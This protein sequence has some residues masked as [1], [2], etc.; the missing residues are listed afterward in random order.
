M[1]WTGKRG[2]SIA[3]DTFKYRSDTHGNERKQVA[4]RKNCKKQGRRQRDRGLSYK[5][6]Y[7]FKL[8]KLTLT[9]LL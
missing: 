9:V 3:A 4:E 5:P 1:L 7:M 6:R 8:R 2:T